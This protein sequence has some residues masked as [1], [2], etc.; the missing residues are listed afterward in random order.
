MGHLQITQFLSLETIV[1]ETDFKWA[2]YVV[3]KYLYTDSSYI[4]TYVQLK[5]KCGGVS[6]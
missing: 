6:E 1:N 5:T 3:K 4:H 2:I